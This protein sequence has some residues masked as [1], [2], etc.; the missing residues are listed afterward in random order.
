MAER[1]RKEDE[2]RQTAEAQKRTEAVNAVARKALDR[3]Q[4]LRYSPLESVTFHRR[5]MGR[6]T[7]WTQENGGVRSGWC[8]TMEERRRWQAVAVTC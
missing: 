4:C 2:R 8:G 7:R 3:R 6:S 1:L 5:R